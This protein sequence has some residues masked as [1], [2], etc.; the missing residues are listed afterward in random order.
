MIFLGFVF[1]FFLLFYTKIYPLVIST[2]DDYFSIANHRQ[3]L[4]EW[5]GSEPARVFPEVFMPLVSQGSALLY[6]IFGG[7]I[8]DW[9]TFGRAFFLAAVITGLSAA[10]YRLLRKHGIPAWQS[11]AGLVIFLLMHF[12]IFKQK[13]QDGSIYML[14]TDCACTCFH[15]VIPNLMN[16]ILVLWLHMDR[17]LHELFR[18]EK[19][20]KKAFF[21]F[22]A[23]LCIFSN[24]WGK[25][26]PGSLSRRE[27]GGGPGDWYS[28]EDRLQRMDSRA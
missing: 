18:P 27:P 5:H 3:I 20:L 7:N 9:L 15:Y 22:Y 24:I 25:Y 26:D 21:V 13:R 12:W 16:A 6:R 4:P 11:C 19:A 10:V 28:P 1:L 17:D 23:Y 2:T 8:L 14:W